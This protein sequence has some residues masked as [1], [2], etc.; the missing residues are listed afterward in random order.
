MNMITINT[1]FD[2]IALALWSLLIWEI[3]HR[4][5]IVITQS[6]NIII[7]SDGLYTFPEYSQYNAYQVGGMLKKQ[8]T[9]IS[10]T[11]SSNVL[12]IYKKDSCQR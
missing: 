2:S 4:R 10:F 1:K 3:L 9:I 11:M 8:I 12:I 7:N 5:D 6:S